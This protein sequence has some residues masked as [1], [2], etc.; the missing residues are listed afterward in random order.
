MI[1]I[2]KMEYCVITFML[3][4][5]LVDYTILCLSIIFIMDI[6]ITLFDFFSY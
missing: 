6:V 2:I 3:I 5:I 4:I 1:I